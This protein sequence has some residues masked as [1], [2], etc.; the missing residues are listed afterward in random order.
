MSDVTVSGNTAVSICI[1]VSLTSIADDGMDSF[2]RQA[3]ILFTFV[4]CFLILTP[5][6]NHI[7]S[8]L[9]LCFSVSCVVAAVSLVGTTVFLL[10]ND[11]IFIS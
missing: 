3:L 7:P 9:C 2:D 6:C 10:D 4:C 1:E 8:L 11:V 5:I